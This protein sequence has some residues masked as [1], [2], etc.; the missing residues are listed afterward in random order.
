MFLSCATGSLGDN[1]VLPC[2]PSTL[3]GKRPTR[4]MC[5]RT[6]SEIVG[7]SLATS[8]IAAGEKY[9]DLPLSLLT[10]IMQEP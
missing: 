7:R 8:A 3:T 4:K 1:M 9:Q 5:G 10:A 6:F 2:T